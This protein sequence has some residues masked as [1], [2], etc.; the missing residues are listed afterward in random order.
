MIE[1]RNI[2]HSVLIITGMHRSGTSLTTS[3]LQSTGIY[4]GDRL[5]DGGNG[6]TKGHFEDL[7]FVELHRR[8]LTQQGVNRE[9]WTTQNNFAFTSEYFVQA[10]NL[11]KAKNNQP[12]WGWKD[13]R[14]TLFLDAWQ[15]LIPN[16]KFVFVYRSPWD[17]VDSLFR[18]GDLIF[19]QDPVIAIQTWVSYNQ[20]ILDFCKQTKHPWILLRIEDVINHPQLIIELI[21]QHL[22]LNL[23]TPQKLYDQ[24]LFKNNSVHLNRAKLIQ[25][26]FPQAFNI[27]LKLHHFA[28]IV[29]N[30][31]TTLVNQ[32]RSIPWFLQNW[33]DQPKVRVRSIRHWSKLKR[34]GSSINL[35]QTTAKFISEAEI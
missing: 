23:T 13:P 15:N 32:S 27:Y 11:I 25:K 5:M 34:L 26:F 2:N 4:I 20:T 3:L 19:K 31:E 14:T 28:S 35:E 17:V 6:N 9:G 1:D 8:C 22:D 29:S 16:A 33:L 18:R 21:N 7:D 30:S 12:I 10:K 24:S